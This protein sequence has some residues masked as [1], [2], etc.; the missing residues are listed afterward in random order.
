M[1]RRY[2]TGDWIRVPLGGDTDVVALIA[3]A[4]QSRLYG[5]FFAV[6][7]SQAVTHERLRALR[8]HDALAA[9]LFGAA[10]IEQARWPI[11]AT[12]LGFDR[13]AWPF[14]AFASRGA[15]GDAW[16]QVRYDPATLQIV[17]RRAIDAQSAAAL[18]DA[19]FASAHEAEALLR[20]RIGGEPS[21][22]VQSLC[23]LRSPID[24]E[25]LRAIERGGRL[26]FSTPLDA[27]D[28]ER[29]AQFME[30]YPAVQLRV[31]GFRSGFDAAQLKRFTSLR[32]LTIDVHRLQH[33]S[34]LATLSALQSLR[35][36]A[37][38]LQLD[39][40]SK[41]PQLRTLELRGTRGSLAALQALTRLRSL[42]LEN[43]PPFDLRTLACGENLQSLALA[44]GSYDLH[45]LDALHG[46]RELELRA[47]DASTLSPL[48]A[49]HKLEKLHLHGLEQVFELDPLAALPRL[50]ELHITGMTQ[51]NVRHFETLQDCAGLQMVEIDVGSRTKE[52]EIYRMLR[53]GNSVK[54]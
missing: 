19:R 42:M 8:P 52:R 3:R 38:Q 48:R 27:A 30:A 16:T 37:M 6:P 53:I 15:F 36:G 35:L 34:T 10:P 49:L 20:R 32:D 31:H 39:F 12:S 13:D 25:R 21:P 47:L 18:A 9:L 50:R 26:Q 46:L 22:R 23:E 11:V 54:S 45:T 14:P 33:A 29:L 40:V 43:T 24:R 4:C 41:L 7:S 17:E 5:Y 44:H 1:K 2:K 51:L 28:L